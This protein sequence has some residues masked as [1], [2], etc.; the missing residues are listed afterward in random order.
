MRI[1]RNVS[2]GPL[3]G[4]GHPNTEKVE[5]CTVTDYLYA[6]LS[7]RAEAGTVVGSWGWVIILSAEY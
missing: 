2:H 7:V 6:L 1:V 3:R 4:I 5:V